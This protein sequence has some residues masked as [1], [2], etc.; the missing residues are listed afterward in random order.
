M[1][2]ARGRTSCS[3]SGVHRPR[4]ARLKDFPYVGIHRYSLR[5]ATAARR[6]VFES[7]ELGTAAIAQIQKTCADEQFAILAYCV[8]P[9][10][11]HLVIEGSCESSDLRRCAK[12]AK[13]RVEYVARKTF[14]VHH[15]WQKGYYERVLRSP[16]ATEMAIRYVLD[17]PVRARLVARPSDYKLS[18]CARARV[19]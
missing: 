3:S 9:D 18:G 15:L 17:N 12:L 8:M 13:Q 2:R 14:H 5:F 16:E 6:R 19:E 1:V 11:V 7:V 10:H 4:P